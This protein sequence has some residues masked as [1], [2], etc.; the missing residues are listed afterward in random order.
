MSDISAIS[1]TAHVRLEPA[2]RLPLRESEPASGVVRGEDRVE[3]S[4]KARYLQRLREVPPVRQELVD[5]IKGE[6]ESGTYET[7]EK[8]A[9]ALDALLDDFAELG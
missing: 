4:D 6:L 1:G 2:P 9:E 7:P 5:R 8:F 3:L